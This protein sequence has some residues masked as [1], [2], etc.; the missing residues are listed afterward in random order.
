MVWAAHRLAILLRR[1]VHANLTVNF[2]VGVFVFV[3]PDT[4]FKLVEVLVLLPNVLSHLLNSTPQ[5]SHHFL[6]KSRRGVKCHK[7]DDERVQS[8][9]KKFALQRLFSGNVHTEVVFQR[10]LSLTPCNMRNN[11]VRR[12]SSLK[13]GVNILRKGVVDNQ[14]GKRRHGH[15]LRSDTLENIEWAE[16]PIAVG[17][18]Q[19]VIPA[20]VGSP[21]HFVG[22]HFVFNRRDLLGLVNTCVLSHLLIISSICN[23]DCRLFLLAIMPSR[24]VHKRMLC[25]IACLRLMSHLDVRMMS[26]LLHSLRRFFTGQILCGV[27][28]LCSLCARYLRQRWRENLFFNCPVQ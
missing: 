20:F 23:I 14:V 12:E 11:A 25:I 8:M 4:D 17:V 24:I 9:V 15:V 10:L 7:I 22:L 6:I 28:S 16:G 18:T 19:P 26:F 21:F 27:G 1:R 3:A 5:H 2:E 13:I